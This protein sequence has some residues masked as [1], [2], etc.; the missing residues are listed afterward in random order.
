[1]SSSIDGNYLSPPL[2][3]LLDICHLRHFS[4]HFQNSFTNAVKVLGFPLLAVK[5]STAH[6][7]HQR[8]SRTE[9]GVARGDEKEELMEEDREV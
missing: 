9:R 1:M 8:C 4:I 5:A 6:T 3:L 2:F 7:K